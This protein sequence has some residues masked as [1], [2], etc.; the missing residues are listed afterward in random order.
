MKT[1]ACTFKLVTFGIFL[2]LVNSC[3]KTDSNN[4]DTTTSDIK[5]I[6]FNPNLTYG[7]MT[8]QSGN[9]YKTI[10]IGT[11]TWM[12][13]NLR[14]TKYRNGENIP[15]VT[16]N[17]TWAGLST[18]AYSDIDNDSR[19]SAIYGRI[20][21]YHVILDTRNIAPLGWHVATAAEWN[22]LVNRCGGW[23]AAGDLLKE[24]G[25]THWA[26]PNSESLN[27]SGFTAIPNRTR[28]VTG[29][30]DDTYVAINVYSEW[31]CDSGDTTTP[32]YWTMNYFTAKVTN[33]SGTY[34][35]YRRDG[36]AIRCVKDN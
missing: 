16:D 1:Y 15:N 28:D 10:V 3:K 18:G 30:W 20:Y 19:N 7:T 33:L 23:L 21:N 35:A 4:Q 27:T 5:P 24:K 32:T 9:T 34:V 14:T 17:T 8:D 13:E 22:I 6:V 2:L 31:W 29:S 12:A 36:R 25:V 11:Q 26:A